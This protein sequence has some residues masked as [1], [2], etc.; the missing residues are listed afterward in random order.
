LAQLSGLPGERVA[1]PVLVARGEPPGGVAAVAARALVRGL[2]VRGF[3]VVSGLSAHGSLG[4]VW[5]PQ[6]GRGAGSPRRAGACAGALSMAFGGGRARFRKGRVLLSP[7]GA[8]VP[9]G[10]PLWEFHYRALSA[11]RPSFSPPRGT[12][13]PAATELVGLALLDPPYAEPRRGAMK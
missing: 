4:W 13:P 9:R 6:A 2:R 10:G 8:I 3:C 11:T 12:G 1:R 5:S 7:T